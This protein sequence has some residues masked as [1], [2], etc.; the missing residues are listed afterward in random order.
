MNLNNTSWQYSS[1][2]LRIVF[3]RT[4]IAKKRF[5]SMNFLASLYFFHWIV[6]CHTLNPFHNLNCLNVFIYQKGESFVLE[7]T[8]VNKTSYLDDIAILSVFLIPNIKFCEVIF[9]WTPVCYTFTAYCKI[10]CFIEFWV[11]N[12]T[13]LMKQKSIKDIFIND[14]KSYIKL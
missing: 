13:V 8:M 5:S 9:C 1:R 4:G 12:F 14:W 2:I 11:R 7:F 10:S 6:F 3:A